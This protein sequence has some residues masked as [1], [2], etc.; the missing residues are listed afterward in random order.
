MVWRRALCEGG[1]KIM[2]NSIVLNIQL[3]VLPI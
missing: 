2:L 1:I 3:S